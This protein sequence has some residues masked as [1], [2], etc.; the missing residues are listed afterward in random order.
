MVD[1][2]GTVPSVTIGVDLGDKY[3][4]VCVLD[5][6]GEIVSE[7]RVQTTEAGLR[8][9]FGGMEPARI[10]L[11][12]GTH[13]SWVAPILRGLGHEVL[14]AN[15]RKLRFIYKSNRKNDRADAESLARVGRLDPRLLFPIEHRD[16]D[17]HA[18]LAVLR[19]RDRLVEVR[20][21]LV[22]H[23]RGVVKAAGGRIPKCSTACFDRKARAHIPDAF[24][25]AIEPILDTIGG[26]TKTIRGYDRQIEELSRDRY[27]E[28]EV[29]RQIDGVGSVT[30]LAFRLTISD[31]SRFARNRTVGA[32]LGLV[33]RQKDS[34]SRVSQLRISK[35]GNSFCRKLL[36]NAAQYVLGPFGPDTDL[37]R[38]GLALFER[39]GK[40]A[41]RRAI[42]AV[43]RKLAVLLLS[44]WQTAEVYEPLRNSRKR[45]AAAVT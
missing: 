42:V 32:Y 11:E 31:P 9:Q 3:S 12:V 21:K 16:L 30:A 41:K 38:W 26:L 1:S 28:T 22:N 14:V 13:S 19:A 7:G 6:A 18:D 29:L 25:P 35:A 40:N 15:A 45:T 37:R 8:L 23:V 34:G 39:G 44:L 4:H 24:R 2:I 20:T 43:A 17:T 33:P 5:E 10:A 27:P 36:V